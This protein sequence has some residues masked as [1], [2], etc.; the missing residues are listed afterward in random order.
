MKCQAQTH[1]PRGLRFPVPLDKGNEGSGDEIGT[2]MEL[3]NLLD[4]VRAHDVF[5]FISCLQR[6]LF[7]CSI[8]FLFVAFLLFAA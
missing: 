4:R 7:V 6:S 8:R 2:R 3:P 5:F 1:R